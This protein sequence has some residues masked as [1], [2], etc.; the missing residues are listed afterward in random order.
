M[1]LGLKGVI[2]VIRGTTTIMVVRVVSATEVTKVI[3]IIRTILL[4]NPHGHFV[5]PDAAH[6]AP[7][8]IR[9][10]CVISPLR[11]SGLIKLLGLLGL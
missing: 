11:L 1:F 6:Y 8:I 4:P 9:S 5:Q 2:S 7:T 3:R 10:I